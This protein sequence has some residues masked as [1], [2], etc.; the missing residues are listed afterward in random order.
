[1]V[2]DNPESI[3]AGMRRFLQDGEFFNHMVSNARQ[4]RRGLT[5]DQIAEAYEHVY[6]Q[7]LLTDRR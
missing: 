1:M 2:Q 3:A 6:Q 7:L 5:W 4:M